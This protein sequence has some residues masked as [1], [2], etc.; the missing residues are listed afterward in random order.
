MY[1]KE[2]S[3]EAMLTAKRSGITPEVNLREHATLTP[4]PSVNKAAKALALKGPRGA[5][6]RSPKE[7]YQWC[8]KRTHVLQSFQITVLVITSLYFTFLIWLL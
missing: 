8:N 1:V 2:V 7:G 5:I 3:S 4:S 6:T